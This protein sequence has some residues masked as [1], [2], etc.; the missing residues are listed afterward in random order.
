MWEIIRYRWSDLYVKI[1]IMW[2]LY[3]VLVNIMGTKI[4]L[5][6]KDEDIEK[7]KLQWQIVL[8]LDVILFILALHKSSNFLFLN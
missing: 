1:W 7:E 3:F 2:M 6:R 4:V 5:N 8:L